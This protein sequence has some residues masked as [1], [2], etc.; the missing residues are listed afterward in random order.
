MT[1]S[2]MNDMAPRVDGKTFVMPVRVYYEDT[3][4]GGVV[5][6][7]NYL[8]FAERAR[9]EMLRFFDIENSTMQDRHG[10]AFVVRHI[11]VEYLSPARLDDLLEVHLSLTK[12]GG[13][14]LSGVQSI[15]RDGEEL[16][17]IVIR[18]GCMKLSGGPGRLP[19]DVLERLKALEMTNDQSDNNN[20]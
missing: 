10:V 6:Y 4:A 20:K 12:V 3:D 2:M 19:K 5:Y 7:A 18:L 14:S 15:W 13:A 8:K 11:D 1:E 17:R 9:T 16:V